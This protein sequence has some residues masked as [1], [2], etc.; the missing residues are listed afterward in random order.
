M[1]CPNCGCPMDKVNNVGG[2]DY[3]V[4]SSCGTAVMD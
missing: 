2:P 4:C 1:R 3:W